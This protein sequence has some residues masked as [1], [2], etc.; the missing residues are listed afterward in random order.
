MLIE[1]QSHHVLKLLTPTQ[2]FSSDISKDNQEEQSRNAAS[3][4][5]SSVISESSHLS[6]D[7]NMNSSFVLSY[8]IE[9]ALINFNL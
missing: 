3:A 7:K 4:M 9:S 8:P 6:Y 2:P 5:H 1:F